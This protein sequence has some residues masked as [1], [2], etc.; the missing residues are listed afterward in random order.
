MTWRNLSELM[1]LQTRLLRQQ[2]LGVDTRVDV[3]M[4]IVNTTESARAMS[5]L[6]QYCHRV[7]VQEDLFI[8]ADIGKEGW[9]ALAEALSWKPGVD[10][11]SSNNCL[12][13]ARREDLRAIWGC[14]VSSWEVWLDE[15]RSQEFGDWEQ[16]E[17]FFVRLQM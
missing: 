14:G 8:E 10:F 17:R 7:I 3:S 15:N 5:T 13:S 1:A 4:L 9:A 12:T 6:M 2:D 11:I 16:F